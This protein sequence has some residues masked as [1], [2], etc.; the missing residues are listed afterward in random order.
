MGFLDSYEGTE[1]IDLGE[2]WWIDVKKCLTSA[3]YQKVQA[4]FGA[5]KQTV[6]MNGKQFATIDPAAAQEELLFQSISDWNLTDAQDQ[7]LPLSPEPARR[8]SISRLPAPVFMQVYQR[9]DELNGPRS[10][11][12]A[13]QFPDGDLS[14]A[15]DGGDA[16]A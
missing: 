11:E 2:G 1:R 14:G 10:N 7:P 3:E 16:P 12:E 5:G 15:E 9:C 8:A 13:A 4:F 6:N